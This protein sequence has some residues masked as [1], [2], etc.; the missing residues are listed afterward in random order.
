[1]NIYLQLKSILSSSNNVQEAFICYSYFLLNFRFKNRSSVRCS[2]SA[3]SLKMRQIERTN[4][5]SNQNGER[6]IICASH[7]N[8]AAAPHICKNT[9]TITKID[10]CDG[11]GTFCCLIL[12]LTF[13]V[14]M[15]IQIL[16][17]KIFDIDILPVDD[18]ISNMELSNSS[19]H[20]LRAND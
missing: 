14:A 9:T 4:A 1:M 2:A 10:Y 11:G 19:I 15:L 16:L 8:V 5:P 20:Q 17:W 6:T 18:S 7:N 3:I 12:I 13:M